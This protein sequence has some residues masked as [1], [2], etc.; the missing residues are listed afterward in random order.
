LSEIV[1]FVVSFGKSQVACISWQGYLLKAPPS[2]REC[3]K[4]A[5]F[6]PLRELTCHR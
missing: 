1:G 4:V 5:G 3:A 6:S 2:I